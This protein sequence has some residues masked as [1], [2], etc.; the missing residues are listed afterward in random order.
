MV[1]SSNFIQIFFPAVTIGFNQSSYNAT[2][3]SDTSVEVCTSVLN[4]ILGRNVTVTFFTT[5]GTAT[6]AG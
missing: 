2:E 4:G 5:D 3:G 1:K 6:S